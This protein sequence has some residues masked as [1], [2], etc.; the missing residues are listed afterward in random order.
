VND[1]DDYWQPD[2]AFEAAADYIVTH[3]PHLLEA[4]LPLPTE[5]VT[6]AELL[7]ELGL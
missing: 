3:D 6:P 2:L 5:V 1:P 7:R 4:E